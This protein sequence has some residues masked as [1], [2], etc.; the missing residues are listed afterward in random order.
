MCVYLYEALADVT[1]A[2]GLVAAGGQGQPRQEEE[3]SGGGGSSGE[4]Q[5]TEPHPDGTPMSAGPQ[6]S[7]GRGGGKHK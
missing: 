4:D 3:Q 7:G 5:P 2:E 6:R 1:G